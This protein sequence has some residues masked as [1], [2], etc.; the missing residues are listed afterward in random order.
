MRGESRSED[1][2]CVGKFVTS[3]SNLFHFSLLD[4][5]KGDLGVVTERKNRNHAHFA[6]KNAGPT[7]TRKNSRNGDGC[8][9]HYDPGGN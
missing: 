8:V 6:D 5:Q 2:N 4:T 1:K 9:K 7:S 3:V